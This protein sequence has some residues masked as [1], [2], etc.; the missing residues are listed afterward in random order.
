[1]SDVFGNDVIAWHLDTRN[2]VFA[3]WGSSECGLL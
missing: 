1:M 2:L 3:T